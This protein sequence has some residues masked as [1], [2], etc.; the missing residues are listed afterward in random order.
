MGCVNRVILLGNLGRDPELRTTAGGDPWVRFPLATSSRWKAA[1]GERRER[2]EWHNVVSYGRPAELASDYLR[3]GQ[4]ICLEG[5]L[6]NRQWQDAEGHKRYGV[7]VVMDRLI[8]LSGSRPAA[9]GDSS[10]EVAPARAEDPQGSPDERAQEASDDGAVAP[11]D[12]PF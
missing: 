3:R 10:S 7:D 6:R 11:D 1:D 4:Q 8:M 2:T 9:D 12:L 5:R